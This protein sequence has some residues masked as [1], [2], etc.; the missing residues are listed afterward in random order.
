MPIGLR[1]SC[2][3]Y[4][5]LGKFYDADGRR[6]GKRR[7]ELGRGITAAIH[8]TEMPPLW[9]ILWNEYPMVILALALMLVL[10]LWNQAFRMAPPVGVAS[11][12]RRSVTEHV[13]GVAQKNTQRVV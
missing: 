3:Y 10:W 5:V 2:R 1:K 4:Q 13:L 7:Y 11:S 12:E 6:D 8:S 9:R